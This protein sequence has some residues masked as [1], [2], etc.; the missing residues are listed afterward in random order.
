MTAD[1]N[2]IT[3]PRDFHNQA[4]M[5]IRQ[6]LNLIAAVIRRIQEREKRESNAQML[7]TKNGVPYEGA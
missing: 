4:P 7:T 1:R 3:K 5:N 2:R 6:S